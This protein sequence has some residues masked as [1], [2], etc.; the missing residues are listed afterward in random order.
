MKITV[1]SILKTHGIRGGVKV[2]V[3]SDNP[4]RFKEG[5]KLYVEDQ[6]LTIEESF[7]LKAEKVIK[8]KEY[9]DINQVQELIGKDLWVDEK[10]LADLADD[11]YYIYKLIGA[12]IISNGQEIGVLKDIISGVYPNDVYLIETKEKKEVLLP[13]LKSVI[14]KI[15]LDE[16]TIQVDNLSDYE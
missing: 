4:D 10:D 9:E 1:A 13:A 16:N 8:F 3:L 11:E 2:K 6:P 12:K 14:K 15:D 7:D 5:S